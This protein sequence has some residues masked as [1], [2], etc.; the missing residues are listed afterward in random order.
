MNNKLFYCILLSGLSINA[1]YSENVKKIVVKGNKRV[2]YETVK[3]YLPIKIG[4]ELTEEKTDDSLKA[5]FD[6]GY[7]EDVQVIGKGGILE[8]EVKENPIVNQISYE[9]N[10]HLKDDQLEKEI[11]IRPRKILSKTDIQNAQQRILEMYRRTGRFNAKVDPKIIKLDNNRVNLIFEIT[12][13]GVSNIQKIIFIGNKAF[14]ASKLEDQLLSKSWKFWRFFATDDVFDPDRFMADQQVLRQFYANNGHPDFR[15]ISAVSEL[16]TDRTEFYLTFT[17]EE[18]DYYQFDTPSIKSDI[19]EVKIK[20]LEKELTFSK[21]DMFSSNQIE[22]SITAITEALGDNGYAFVTVE[23]VIVKDKKSKMATVNFEIKEGPR[24]YIHKI[25][26][27]GNDKTYDHVIRRELTLYEGDAYNS[28]KIRNSETKIKDL[29]YFKSAHIEHEQGEEK[30]QAN[31]II[32][33]EEQSTGEF[34]LSGGYSTL[35]G[36]IGMLG[37]SQKNFMGRGQTIHSEISASQKSQNFNVGITEPYLFNRPLVGSIDIY[38]TRSQYLDTFTSESLGLNT[39][40]GYR[41]TQNLI[42]KWMYSIHSDDMSGVNSRS[43]IFILEDPKKMKQST[44]THTLRYDKR[45][46]ILD[47][48]RG[49]LLNL[50]TSYSGV[51]GDVYYI[52]N[53]FSST[54]YYTPYENLLTFARLDLGRVDQIQNKRL[55]VTDSIFLGSDSFKGFEYG[56]LGP[57]DIKSHYKDALGGKKYWKATLEA[58]LPIG[59]SIDWGIKGVLFTQAG[60]L[61][62]SDFINSPFNDGIQAQVVDNKKLRASY[63]FGII[64]KSPFGPLRIDYAVPF[65]KEPFDKEMRL[66]IGYATPF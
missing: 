41:L 48:T 23:P 60:M 42:Q 63:G 25:L 2:E 27:K 4:E 8:I 10:S 15:I 54:V 59:P 29:G 35:E 9:G 12:E 22:K 21:G 40:I 20:D 44:I 45:D 62:D 18:G 58:Q 26:F 31:L 64:W 39:G 37:I 57:R 43:S 36:V 24:I 30:D 19:K 49:Y 34:K 28:S 3:S 38:K 52:R 65:I 61:W 5:L 32:N 56:G 66:N 46:S 13:G 53:D 55:R 51:G 1:L 47:T 33:V 7:F 14:S 17:I 6:T 16:S 50:N 11:S